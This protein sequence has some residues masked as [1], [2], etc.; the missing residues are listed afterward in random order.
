MEVTGRALKLMENLE[1]NQQEIQ[2][3]AV[4]AGRSLVEVMKTLEEEKAQRQ[5]LVVEKD[6]EIRGWI[7]AWLEDKKQGSQ[8]KGVLI[9][10][11]KMEP[12][13]FQGVFEALKGGQDVEAVL[14]DQT[15]RLRDYLEQNNVNTED[16]LA[17]DD[18]IL[19]Y[20]QNWKDSLAPMMLN[21]NPIE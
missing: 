15:K 3:L 8:L 13:I 7:T 10:L 1:L 18:Q 4:R 14:G 19:A 9:E 21:A 20:W 16:I 5:K 12:W 6:K 2:N 17:E 11:W